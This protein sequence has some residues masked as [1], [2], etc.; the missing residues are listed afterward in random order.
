MDWNDTNDFDAPEYKHDR[1]ASG[2]RKTLKSSGP[3]TGLFGKLKVQKIR[4]RSRQESKH[5]MDIP[6]SSGEFIAETK[7]LHKNGRKP[8]TFGAKNKVD[9]LKFNKEGSEFAAQSTQ[10]SKRGLDIPGRR[11]D[12]IPETEKLYGGKGKPEN[13]R[14]QSKVKSLKLR[15][16]GIKFASSH[17]A[18]QET[19]NIYGGRGNSMSYPPKSKIKPLNASRGEGTKFGAGG[20]FFSLK[21]FE[22]LGSS[23]DMLKVLKAQRIYRPS[24][25]QLFLVLDEES[26]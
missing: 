20:D 7:N 9:S 5:E 21:S 3:S 19:E 22:D 11:W 14:P 12:F 16:E 2:D 23:E 26:S 17:K 24:H 15:R 18:F 25:I 6:S 10:Q 4:T 1:Y 13:D 8:E